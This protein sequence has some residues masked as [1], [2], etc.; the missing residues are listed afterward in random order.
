MSIYMDP[1]K[2]RD[3][4][5]KEK[6]HAHTAVSRIQCETTINTL[7]VLFAAAT[8]M[9]SASMLGLAPAWGFFVKFPIGMVMEE[10]GRESGETRHH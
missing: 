6:G 4:T 8:P 2:R 5:A 10:G 1:G 7:H 3:T 9:E